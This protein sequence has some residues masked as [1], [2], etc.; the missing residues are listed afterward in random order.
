MKNSISPEE[1]ERIG[2]EIESADSPVGIDARKTHIFILH[3][4]ND[5]IERLERLE[6][7]ENQNESD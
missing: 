1:Y 7:K 6:Q 5:I 2:K 4:L 3:K